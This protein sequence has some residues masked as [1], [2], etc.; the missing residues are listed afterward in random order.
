MQHTKS[1]EVL[2]NKPQGVKNVIDTSNA[3]EDGNQFSVE[4]ASA[5]SPSE[6]LDRKDDSLHED[7][8]EGSSDLIIDEAC[9]NDVDD[10]LI[11]LFT[12]KE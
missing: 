1:A 3:H 12:D 8:A 6:P 11:S 5:A 10:D 9:D 7:C 4:E 2:K